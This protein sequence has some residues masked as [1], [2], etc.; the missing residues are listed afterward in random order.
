MTDDKHNPLAPDC[1]HCNG[2]GVT[3]G[4][5][6]RP[7]G[8][9]EACDGTGRGAGGKAYLADCA[10]CDGTGI[11][12]VRKLRAIETFGGNPKHR[13]RHC[14]G[15]G[16]VKRDPAIVDKARE[17]TKRIIDK[18]KAAND[19]TLQNTG[20]DDAD[21]H[22]VSP[23]EALLRVVERHGFDLSA[24]ARDVVCTGESFV[25]ILPH[26]T[27][28]EKRA[29]VEHDCN[30]V[31]PEGLVV[32]VQRRGGGQGAEVTAT[33]LSP[34]VIATRSA[35]PPVLCVECGKPVE[36]ARECYAKPTC[37][38]C[39]PPP[40]PLPECEPAKL[41]SERVL[42]QQ[43]NGAQR[44]R[45]A[46]KPKIPPSERAFI[47]KPLPGS[48]IGESK[49][50]LDLSDL[51][52]GGVVTE[53]QLARSAEAL[54]ERG[55]RVAS[56]AKVEPINLIVECPKCGANDWTCDPLSCV[57]NACGFNGEP[58]EGETIDAQAFKAFSHCP[59]PEPF[60]ARVKPL[61]AIVGDKLADV[62][63]RQEMEAAIRA[64]VPVL[65][66]H[67]AQA[68]LA[69]CD[70]GSQHC[71]ECPA[72]G[73]CDNTAIRVREPDDAL[74]AMREQACGVYP[75]EP[76]PTGDIRFEPPPDKREPV[77]T[78]HEPTES[79]R[80]QGIMRAD[81]SIP[82]CPLQPGLGANLSSLV[83]KATKADVRKILERVIDGATDEMVRAFLVRLGERLDSAERDRDA[84][85]YSAAYWW[86]H[87]QRA[88]NETV[89]KATDPE[90][91]A[92]V[93]GVQDGA[94]WREAIEWALGVEADP[95]EHTTEWAKELVRAVR[96]IGNKAH[97]E[98]ET[99]RRV[100]RE[101]FGNANDPVLVEAI[102]HARRDR[103]GLMPEDQPRLVGWLEELRLRRAKAREPAFDPTKP[104]R[105]V[106][107]P[108][109][110][111][112]CPR[113]GCRLGDAD[114]CPHCAKLAAFAPV[115][116]KGDVMKL[117]AQVGIE[118]DEKTKRTLSD[119][120][121]AELRARAAKSMRPRTLAT[122]G[123]M[124]AALATFGLEV[125]TLDDSDG[126]VTVG[127]SGSDPDT[128]PAIE[129]E[130]Q[131][132]MPATLRLSLVPVPAH[133]YR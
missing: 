77:V 53:E 52:P 14:D 89:P 123:D 66:K 93:P 113:C 90:V 92:L 85:R 31:M 61:R 74:V 33:P 8:V 1:E 111:P 19:E 120:S 56:S 29:E 68:V 6:A 47:S 130:L 46:Y 10:E 44:E 118:P 17:L 110:D 22:V 63:T 73:C 122:R 133:P 40:E 99:M 5:D 131:E 69:K 24:H 27:P 57:C 13:C 126:S 109:D 4:G 39:L 42:L 15:T 41:P 91:R 128:L 79:E 55:E 112:A 20:R 36:H 121:E 60:K 104:A 80:E 9:C 71:S 100:A 84:Y 86:T 49:P 18:A 94:K 58:S 35:S 129:R 64:V 98:A 106:N 125:V 88:V 115:D 102:E 7:R 119:M 28:E 70:R 105:L 12:P 87:Y 97:V 34:G 72:F 16:K 38:A 117:A 26:D 37:Y 32:Y 116:G 2:E 48:G 50:K 43:A 101:I 82:I 132:S 96:E 124:K 108:D 51:T 30:A 67:E 11:V 23:R 107:L 78:V 127:V 114:Y 25:M 76:D 62:N 75:S 54:T 59:A 83:L 95:E 21:P 103:L 3:W 45:E 65:S 81:V